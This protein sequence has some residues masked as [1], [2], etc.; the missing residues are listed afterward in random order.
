MVVVDSP[1]TLVARAEL[2]IRQGQFGEACSIVDEGLRLY[3]DNPR[4]TAVMGRILLGQ[5][6]G[7]AAI[8][9]FESALAARPDDSEILYYLALAKRAAGETDESVKLLAR[10]AAVEPDNPRVILQSARLVIEQETRFAFRRIVRSKRQV[11]AL[12]QVLRAL[13]L[14]PEDPDICVEAA[15][16]LW[17]GNCRKDARQAAISG[18]AVASDHPRLLEFLFRFSIVLDPETLI[19]RGIG[20]QGRW[21]MKGAK[22]LLEGVP[23]D[24]L[25]RHQVVSWGCRNS[26]WLAET[27]LGIC[28]FMF[29]ALLRIASGD[30]NLVSEG[31]QVF[32]TVFVVYVTCVTVCVC[33][34]HA[35]AGVW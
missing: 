5:D 33:C 23:D 29:V 20:G 25:A 4:L 11:A 12:Q 6:L 22:Q 35:S 32:W 15:E 9:W 2:L 31:C 27:P 3:E 18:L 30:D 24:C 26:G 17:R 7:I 28:L 10:C 16:L 14:A 21:R 8:P 1:R 34:S 13:S 19:V